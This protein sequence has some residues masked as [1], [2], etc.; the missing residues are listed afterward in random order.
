MSG[1]ISTRDPERAEVGYSDA[2]LQ[3]LAADG[4]LLTPSEYPTLSGD[5][6]RAMTDLHYYEIFT[7]VKSKFIGDDIPLAVQEEIAREVYSAD[8]FECVGGN[9]V[10]LREVKEGFF[11]QDL[12]LGPTAAF[13]DMALQPLAQEVNYELTRRESGLMMLGATS[14]DTGS[15]AESAFQGLGKIGMII[16]SPLEGTMTR[17]QRAQM[18]NLSGG[19]ISNVSIDGDFDACQGIV[20]ELKKDPELAGLGAVNSINWGRIA[21]QVPYYVSGYLQAVQGEVGKPVDFVV[22]T[23]NF[24]NILAGHIAREMGVPIRR[25]IVATNEN[26]VVHDVIQHGVYETRQAEPTSSPSMDISQASNFERLLFDILGGDAGRVDQYMRLFSNYGRVEFSEVGLGADE[27]KRIGF[28]SGVSKHANRLDM[29][30]WIYQQTRLVIDPHTADA[31]TVARRKAEQG[32]PI[33][34]M[35]TAKPVKFE[36]TIKEALGFVP[37]RDPRFVGL[38]DGVEGGFVV[39]ENDSQAVK[40]HL[41]G[42]A[43]RICMSNYL[44]G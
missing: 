13:K 29:I 20:K 15:A 44:A 2:I 30:K 25:L 9:V 21:S 42:F 28:D 17:F 8:K 18:A 35:S 36:D 39:L 43:G 12:S 40:R 37:T 11:I 5:E 33:V 31:V 24:G 7:H 26:S 16:L 3:G 34:C 19:N 22:P 27:L 32:V 6:L 23:G 38:E 4:G 41:Q 10:P 1:L 14:G